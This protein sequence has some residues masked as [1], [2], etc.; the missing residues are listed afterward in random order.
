[1]QLQILPQGQAQDGL[2]RP[3]AENGR[4]PVPALG[5]LFYFPKA[6]VF[7]KGFY[8]LFPLLRRP[9]INLSEK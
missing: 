4:Q 7:G 1:M 9:L 6:P 8:P 3:P 5:K 2:K